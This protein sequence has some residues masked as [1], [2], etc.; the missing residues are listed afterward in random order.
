MTERPPETIKSTEVG[1]MLGYTARHVRDLAAAGK[2]PSAFRI[3]DTSQWRFVR[4][5]VENWIEEL[6]AVTRQR[7][8]WNVGESHEDRASREEYERAIGL[9]GRCPT[10]SK[11]R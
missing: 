10:S 8:S 7:L 4:E 11:S 3:D 6:K 5:S 1:R 9:R 2:I